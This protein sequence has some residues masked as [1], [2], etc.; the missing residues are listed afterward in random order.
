MSEPADEEVDIP[1][2][3]EGEVA[4]EPE[5]ASAA[6]DSSREV[7]SETT[8]PAEEP[9]PEEIEDVDGVLDFSDADYDNALRKLTDESKTMPWER[10]M[11]AS[12]DGASP[13]LPPD[14]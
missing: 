1:E 10:L 7:L 8:E 12:P 4:V 2:L 13:S 6:E 9:E 3:G 14:A 11:F 5:V